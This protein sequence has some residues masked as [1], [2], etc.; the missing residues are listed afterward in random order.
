MTNELTSEL[1]GLRDLDP[2]VVSRMTM[3]YRRDGIVTVTHLIPAEIRRRAHAEALRLLENHAE[4]RE[5]RLATTG[6]TPRRMSVVRSE[7]IASNSP[8]LQTLYDCAELRNV[9][10]EIAGEQLI[11]CPSRD[12]QFLISRHEMKGD[13]HGW[14]WGDYPVALIWVLQAPPIEDG[15]LLQCVPHTYWNKS[16]PRI[17]TFL[18]SQPIRTY[19]FSSGDVYFLRTDTTLHRTTPLEKE[20]IRIMLNLTWSSKRSAVELKHSDRW[21][22]NPSADAA[23]PLQ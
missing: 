12:E 6:N 8:L 20:T 3:N 16:D 23:L 9:F 15:G 11:A 4:R 10:G 14:H 19:H 18:C 13:T 1:K 22:E 5:L 2:D 7:V 17:N 21:W